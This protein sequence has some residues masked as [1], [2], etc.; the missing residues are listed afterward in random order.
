M[1][2][3]R[4]SY[5]EAIRLASVRL[6]IPDPDLKQGAVEMIKMPS[7]TAN[8]QMPWANGGG[9]AIVYKF[10]TQRGHFKA[11]RCF[12][13]DMT[14]DTQQRYE[15]MSR[16]F[17]RHMPTITAGFQYYDSG[18]N[19][20]RSGQAQLVSRPVIVMDWIDGGR[21]IDK[22]DE[23]CKKRDSVALGRLVDQWLDIL[24]TLRQAKMAHGD[25]TSENIMLN[26]DGRLVLIDYDGVYIPDFQG[27][28]PIVAGQEAYQHPQMQKRPFNERMDDFSAYV[29]YIAL[30]ALH[31]RPQLWDK[32]NKLP[33]NNLLFTQEDFLRPEQSQLFRELEQINNT[34][35]RKTLQALKQAC[36]LPIEQIMLPPL[37]NDAKEKESLVRLKEAIDAKD[38]ALIVQCWTPLLANY[39]QAQQYQGHVSAAQQ[40]LEALK[41]FRDALK[42]GNIQRIVAS[43]AS[44]LYN[45]NA[46][47]LEEQ[48]CLSLAQTFHNAYQKDDDEGIVIAHNEI[49]TSPLRKRFIFTP[50]EK[51]RIQ[52]AQRYKTALTR[53]RLAWYRTKN[54]KEI[55]AAYDPLFETYKSMPSDD[56]EVL[57]AA[58]RFITMYEATR[59]AIAANNNAGD[60]QR[61]FAVYDKDL[62]E[63]FTDF[64]LAEK[65]R[66]KLALNRQLL[67]YAIQR[68]IYREVIRRTQEIENQ[69]QEVLKDEVQRKAVSEA[70]RRYLAQFQPKNVEVQVK[71]Q[72]SCLAVT[73]Q[74]P[75][76]TLIQYAFVVWHYDRWPLYP[77]EAGAFRS[78]PIL[79]QSYE[80]QKGFQLPVDQQLHPMVYLQVYFAIQDGETFTH[81]PS[82]LYSSGTEPTS[83]CVVKLC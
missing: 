16:F 27:M 63:R 78:S 73:W 25:F 83:R 13:V 75:V 50:Q 70:K 76:D 33:E 71:A 54:A 81:G 61:I 80:L 2:G 17:A 66:I 79:R 20:K 30:L 69:T 29:I 36:A 37:E 77:G 67:K 38:D 64:T 32:Y 7:N 19:I 26:K 10:R 21:L 52:L 46:I 22:V 4:D 62:A 3:I 24:R 59:E 55:V 42:A 74:W 9:F 45:S 43:S 28:A 31:L 49:T 5:N 11:I 47:T 35:L 82:W 56:Q 40:R 12:L 48:Q 39:A 44:V 57:Q 41:R 6:K 23:L 51:Q 72:N 68:N 65:E 53:F 15:L 8:Y 58:Q 14:S 34:N 1:P 60:D 18:I